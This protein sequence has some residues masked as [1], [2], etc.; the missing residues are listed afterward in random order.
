MDFQPLAEETASLSY[1]YA[2]GKGGKCAKV[3][4][5]INIEIE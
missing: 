5:N 1:K 3:N 4:Q 2:P